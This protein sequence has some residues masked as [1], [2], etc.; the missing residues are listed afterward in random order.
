MIVWEVLG[1]E[2]CEVEGWLDN[3]VC[4]VVGVEV[5]GLEVDGKRVFGCPSLPQ[6]LHNILT[7]SYTSCCLWDQT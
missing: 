7:L 1:R 5:I 4:M 3:G 6:A 2:L